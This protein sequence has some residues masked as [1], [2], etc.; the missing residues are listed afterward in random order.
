MAEGQTT[1]SANY[2][3]SGL[4]L[5]ASRIAG[6][7]FS[8]LV[9]R[10]LGSASFGDFVLILGI[11]QFLSLWMDLGMRSGALRFIA[12]ETGRN[13]RDQARNYFTSTF[14]FVLLLCLVLTLTAF[15]GRAHI[16]AW[17]GLSGQE[18]LLGYSILLSPWLTL[19]LYLMHVLQ[20]LQQ[21]RWAVM[22]KDWIEPLTR[23]L[24]CA[25][26]LAIGFQLGAAVVPFA[27]SHGVVAGL[28]ACLIFRCLGLRGWKI[29][30]SHLMT[31]FQFSFPLVLVSLCGYF[32]E[33]S[34]KLLLGL[35]LPRAELGWYGAS[36][37]WTVLGGIPLQALTP[38]FLPFITQL[39][40]ADKK[41]EVA[42]VFKRTTTWLI[43]FG[44]FILALS[45]SFGTFLMG[46]FGQEFYEMGSGI[47]ILL[48]LAAFVNAATGPGGAIFYMGGHSKTMFYVSLV[49]IPVAVGLQVLFIRGWGVWGA[50][51]A[52]ILLVALSNTTNLILI[53]ILE[54]MHPY[55]WTAA[56]ALGIG[57]L[58]GLLSGLGQWN[59]SEPFST[60]FVLFCWLLIYPFLLY[61]FAL[62]AEDREMVRRFS[63]PWNILKG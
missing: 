11:A 49:L 21:F 61:R 62:P 43:I 34:D 51:V 5:C 16:S 35:F 55:S 13:N 59:L 8:L 14:S 10:S 15:Q 52:S 26:G 53:W 33:W 9:A 29:R 58:C 17:L 20:G 18:G 38:I 23:L 44:C 28:A 39:Y 3:F 7:L 25:L 45:V 6:F 57:C 12:L 56:R 24:G 1:L 22:L 32:L 31:A 60:A 54:R 27:A 30:W 63:N 40:G 47:L 46:F 36:Q 42:A 48:S 2:A 41:G 50:A 4:S 37:Q 19:A